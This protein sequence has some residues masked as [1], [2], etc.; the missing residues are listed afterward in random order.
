MYSPDHP[1]ACGELCSAA[2]WA[3]RFAGSSPR[4]RGTPD[5]MGFH[6]SG[7][8]IIPAH[9]G[10]S[11]CHSG[12]KALAPDHP[13]ACG[14]LATSAPSTTPLIGS[15]PRMRGTPH[16]SES[17]VHSDRIIPA[18]AGN[19]CVQRI[20]MRLCSDHPRACGE[21]LGRRSFFCGVLGS[22]P[23]MRG[24]RRDPARQHMIMRIIPAHAG[25]SSRS[26]LRRASCSDH[27]RACGE[28]SVSN[29]LIDGSTGSSPRM[30]GTL[31][32]SAVVRVVDRIIPAHAGNS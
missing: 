3:G 26:R 14:E 13:R 19:S 28:L 29:A 18:H 5:K 32:L 1:R 24:T 2:S 8:R 20:R 21:L 22:S 4:M 12:G 6:R 25:N 23:R 7:I 16:G 17:S 9:A 30:R 31:R 11:V 27:P 15:S 10:N